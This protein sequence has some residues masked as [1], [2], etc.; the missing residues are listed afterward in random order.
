MGEHVTIPEIV[1]GTGLCLSP[2]LLLATLGFLLFGCYQ[3]YLGEDW[4]KATAFF[5]ASIACGILGSFLYNQTWDEKG[6]MR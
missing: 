1:A 4:T 3:L 6:E 5:L 2:L